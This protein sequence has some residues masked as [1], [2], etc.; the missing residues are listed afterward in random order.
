MK[1]TRTL[2]VSAF[3]LALAA[4]G[5]AGATELTKRQM[6]NRASASA[7]DAIRVIELLQNKP[8]ADAEIESL[9][10]TEYFDAAVL[11]VSAVFCSDQT[12]AANLMCIEMAKSPRAISRKRNENAVLKMRNHVYVNLWGKMAPKEIDFKHE[13]SKD[14]LGV[15]NKYIDKL[16]IR[17][18]LE[19]IS[20]DYLEA[21]ITLEAKKGKTFSEQDLDDYVGIYC[22]DEII[23]A[24]LECIKMS[25]Q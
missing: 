16:P 24:N 13:S 9:M 17:D 10:N 18:K 12:N 21:I 1:F 11:A 7:A 4:V 3:C 14:F 23:V 5:L 25:P 15:R 20:P 19:L 2:R 6:L 22:D 8:V